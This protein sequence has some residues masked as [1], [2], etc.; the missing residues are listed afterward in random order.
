V[1]RQH[2]RP[3]LKSWLEAVS[4]RKTHQY[5]VILIE[6]Q[7]I[8]HDNSKNNKTFL[9]DKIRFD[10]SDKASLKLISMKLLPGEV[11]STIPECI[12]LISE[13]V[14]HSTIM[15]LNQI[16][17]DIRKLAAQQNDPDWNFFTFFLTKESKA[18]ALCDLGLT[19]EAL[20]CYDEL[21]A[22]FLDLNASENDCTS[23]FESIL[24]VDSSISGFDLSPTNWI[25]F[26]ELIHKNR[27]SLYEFRV[28]LLSRQIHILKESKD[29]ANI[30]LR[31]KEFVCQS[32]FIEKFDQKDKSE[33]IFGV[34]FFV[35][36]IIDFES[37]Q[38]ENRLELSNLL[39]EVLI[40]AEGQVFNFL[41]YFRT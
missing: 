24:P 5:I 26:R 15:N 25:K 27:I 14:Y 33:W 29:K 9:L 30:L 16:D 2:F 28:Y 17:E 11:L 8:V 41:L 19:S 36:K 34:I 21:E 10:F 39:A 20:A 7:S 32:I 6:D 38:T 18:L 12:N 23:K 35:L 40:L 37:I 31:C 3:K 13:S 1:Y 22:L 4:I